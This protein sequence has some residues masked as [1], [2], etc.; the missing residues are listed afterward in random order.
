MSG[1]ILK[2]LTAQEG[3]R[4]V[5]VQPS[6]RIL[7]VFFFSKYLA[8]TVS[9]GYDCPVPSF[10]LNFKIKLTLFIGA[11]GLEEIMKREIGWQKIK[12]KYQ[13]TS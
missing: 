7:L 1:G 5:S 6:I 13:A 11:H 9:M 3:F 2:S 12:F 8:D 10:I 4:D